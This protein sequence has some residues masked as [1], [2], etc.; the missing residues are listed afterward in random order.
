MANS[1]GTLLVDIKGDTTHLINSFNRA[2][3]AVSKTTQTMGS[4]VKLLTGVFASLQAIDLA[5]GYA[6]QVDELQNVNNRL[7]LVVKS[8]QDLENV[9]KKIFEQSQK[10][11][12]SFTAT[13]DLYTRM[14]N[15]TK[16]LNLSQEK[17][18]EIT[19]L[20][21]KSMVISGTSSANQKTMLEQ[22]GQ[23]FS[24]NFQSVGQEF[25]TMKDQAPKLYDA[26]IQ[27]MVETNKQFKVNVDRGEEASAVFKKWAEAGKLSNQIITEALM[28]Q[29]D[30]LS[31]DFDKMVKTIEQSI[32][33]SQNSLQKLISEFDNITGISKT[34]SSSISDVAENIDKISPEKIGKFA[35]SLKDGTIAVV[36][37]Y[38]SMKVASASMSAYNFITEQAVAKNK[39]LID[40]ENAKAKAI[41]LGEQA[42]KTR[43]LADE[44][45]NVS[46]QSGL[47][48]AQNH[49]QMLSKEALK[50]EEAAKKQQALSYQIEASGKS[51]GI[52]GI[53]ANAFRGALAS[54]PF[55]LI[56]SSIGMV[57]TSLLSA[58]KAS[59]TLENTL[60]STGDE[61]KKLT[62]NQ[63]Q[64]RKE[65]VEQEL[66]Q[67]RLDMA[68]AK[69]RASKSSANAE[70]KALRDE[71]VKNFEE[72]TQKLRE[73]KQIQDELS[74]PTQTVSNTPKNSNSEKPKV[75][76]LTD[77]L[78]AIIDKSVLIKREYE[79]RFAKLKELGQDT[80]ENM[81]ILR[82]KEAEE[83]KA[84][85][86]DEVKEAK[87]TADEQKK[88]LEDKQ[89]QYISYYEK[90]GDYS[91]L[92]AEQERKIREENYLLKK[93]E[94]DKLVELEKQNFDN[95]ANENV[96]ES[97]KVELDFQTK[98]LELQ[99]DSYEKEVNLANLK[100]A[101]NVLNI[102][103][104]DKTREQKD[105]LLMLEEQL[106][107][108]TLQRISAEDN[109]SRLEKAS[110]DK[111]GLI[112][113]QLELADATDSWGNSL[114]AVAGKIG[115]V[116]GAY[117]K[118]AKANLVSNKQQIKL[119]TNLAKIKEQ[120]GADSIEYAD[121]VDEHTMKS[122]ELKS[123]QQD[124]EIAGYSNLAGAMAS[125]F[126][127]GS[128]GAI[129]F[130]TIQSALGIASSWTAIANAWA[131]PFPG[132]LA[133]VATVTSAVLP[134]ISQLGGSGSGGGGGDT[135]DISAYLKSNEGKGSVLGS[136]EQ[137]SESFKNSIEL[138]SD[139]AEPQFR[140]LQTMSKYLANIETKLGGVSSLIFKGKFFDYQDLYKN[141]PAL[142]DYGIKID[143]QNM[144]DAMNSLNATLYD[145]IL[146]YDVNFR[147]ANDNITKQFSMVLSDIYKTI[148]SS[149]LMLGVDNEKV[150]DIMNQTNINLGKISVKDKTGEEVQ[151]LLSNVFGQVADELVGTSIPLVEEFQ[152]IGE[153]LFETVSRITVGVEQSRFYAEKLGNVFATKGYQ[154][155]QNKQGDVGF[156]LLADAI[157]RVEKATFNFNDGL[158]NIIQSLNVSAEELYNYYTTLD[159]IRDKM[160]FIRTST[161]GLTDMMIRGAG[162]IDELESGFSSFF[163][164][165]L[166]ETDQLIF[167][168]SQLSDSFKSLGVKLPASKDD[169][170]KLVQSIDLTT[171]SGQKLY[172]R[173]MTL[174]ES[175]A[176]VSDKVAESI[177]TLE[178]SLT[179]LSENGID[180]LTSSVEPL[181]N[182]IKGLK[183]IATSFINSFSSS[184]TGST[185]DQIKKYNELRKQFSSYFDENGKLNANATESQAKSLYQE[186]SSIGT[187]IGKSQTDL[188][189]DLV[190]QFQN[191]LF[192]LDLSDQILKVDIVDGLSSLLGL[193]ETQKNEL[194]KISSDGNI[195][196]EELN[197]INSLTEDQRAG[198]LD[199]A[200]NSGYFSTEDTLRNVAEL[201]RLQL[202]AA[203]QS[204]A[205]E[206]EG[207]SR[208]TLSLGDYIGTQ[209]KIDISRLLGT[210]YETAQPLISKLQGMSSL[211]TNSYMNEI[212]KMVGFS[213]GGTTYDAVTLENIN[214]LS[215][216]LRDGAMNIASSIKNQANSNSQSKISDLVNMISS[217]SS[218]LSTSL[219]TIN[220]N[221]MPQIQTY[222]SQIDSLNAWKQNVPM[223]LWGMIDPDIQKYTNLLNVAKES[224]NNETASITNDLQPKINAASLELKSLRGYAVGATNIPY[225]QIAQIHQGEMII[226]KTFSEGL[227]A[228]DLTLGAT[229]PN[230]DFESFNL[231][232]GIKETMQDMFKSISDYP[233]KTHDLLDEVINGRMSM[234]VET[235]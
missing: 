172:G 38:A 217:L 122:S 174:S 89:N 15:S 231:I 109:I 90:I 95:K 137:A 169:F 50:L 211:D 168:T 77:E 14:A 194:Q 183:D 59:E 25:N 221:Y 220:S 204:Q 108:V 201:T 57:A 185:R 154:E 143:T 99:A 164:N 61:L 24:S 97:S 98:L 71:A 192:N 161:A 80:A 187:N 52:A 53:A 176:N 193:N 31:S 17:L 4:A 227:R 8:S 56:A 198:I 42:T 41:S 22:L 223:I 144:K 92:W 115:N 39:H 72:Q 155:I 170:V 224:L 200:K 184:N 51:F 35:E 125:A 103:A 64:Y 18:L 229:T 207:L 102:E 166:S 106:N 175:F 152:K 235:I 136:P 83:I 28:S 40:I 63:L 74:K 213:A 69:A 76:P 91:K 105:Y 68:N 147:K 3:N 81:K 190:S 225:D 203:R 121:A 160:I 113:Y 173:L 182:A 150:K 135:P 110:E 11:S 21:N 148:D 159:V 117:Q 30:A 233:K 62:N 65:L 104:L 10:N 116:M 230:V 179:T 128:A 124:A 132:N 107:Q 141:S 94:L 78:Q 222:Q 87:K 114:D 134:I 153:G 6:K 151:T 157:I 163:D 27:G 146:I 70:D 205:R 85:N 177:K 232:E 2:E 126:E 202:D 12:V 118:M 73:I 195:T 20:I 140:E 226:P 48:I 88:T 181:I 186:L 112:D 156:E 23:A 54:I 19:D 84:L 218:R 7:G 178:E 123:K 145:T 9:Q 29:R 142:S 120:F 133:A 215:P 34:V 46:R 199:F 129:A 49:Y 158:I 219:A 5:K 167:E 79:D 111:I 214:R 191:D 101:N 60:K 47:I 197:S 55:V 206:I 234:K 165:F 93:D 67:T 16:N 216:Y 58:S 36:T 228:G 131:L 196:N 149:A 189:N 26:I 45:L 44:A 180:D 139:Y 138:L 66:I 127:K 171:E 82:E 37:M 208:Q 86:K 130:S 96:Y 32:T 210:S 1:L 188:Q 43:K 33:K 100:Y 162:S 212:Y 75:K 13:A 119:D 209:E